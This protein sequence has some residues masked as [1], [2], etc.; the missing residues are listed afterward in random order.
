MIPVND[1]G[2]E[3][4]LAAW[5]LEEAGIPATNSQRLLVAQCIRLLARE[6]GD[7]KDAAAYIL[8]QAQAA[9]L[10]G[11][12]VNVFWFTDQRY[13]PRRGKMPQPGGSNQRHVTDEEAYLTWQSMSEEYRK[14]NPWRSR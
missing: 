12:C 14:A 4:G 8:R 2:A 3:V 10:E 7:V 5:L 13:K 6:G 11:E 1:A 9:L